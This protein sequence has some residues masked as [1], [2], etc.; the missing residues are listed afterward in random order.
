MLHSIFSPWIGTA[1]Y[2]RGWHIADISKSITNERLNKKGNVPFTG[3][4]A[5]TYEDGFLSFADGA[6]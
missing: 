2:F 3:Q 1:Q 6:W 4:I 5:W